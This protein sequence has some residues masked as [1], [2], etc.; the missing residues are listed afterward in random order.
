[1]LSSLGVMAQKNSETVYLKN[2]SIVRGEVIEQV[3]GQSLKIQ[4]RDGSVFVYQYDEVDRVTKETGSHGL[5][6][7]GHGHMG[8]DYTVDGGFTV[9]K[10]G[11]FGGSAGVEIGKRFTDKFYWGVGVHIGNGG[12]DNVSIPV[13]STLKALFPVNDSGIAPNIMLRGGYVAK[14]ESGFINFMPGVQIPLCKQVD[15][16]INLGYAVGIYDGG[17]SHSFVFN[18][19]FG[20]HKAYDK[21][22]IIVPTRDKGLQLTLEANPIISKNIKAYGANILVG[23]KMTPNISFGVG[24]NHSFAF[25]DGPADTHLNKFYLN[26][27]YRLTDKKV[28]PFGSVDLGCR[29]YSRDEYKGSFMF[30]PA[31]GVSVRTTNNSYVEIKA[32]YEICQKIK[33]VDPYG[34]D[35]GKY[36][37]SA[38]SL[39]VGWTH[40]FKFFSK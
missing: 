24:Y 26:G 17:A 9:G 22:R 10:G 25:M 34:N 13:F 38:F 36:G 12:R 20:F 2:G 28:S 35:T 40:T 32:G 30:T 37:M 29:C 33:Y 4:T 18:A 15:L 31:V 8:L 11:T 6:N 14:G 21:E 1:M 7:S 27:R 3:P 23:Y 5:Y 39:S 19:G 16:N